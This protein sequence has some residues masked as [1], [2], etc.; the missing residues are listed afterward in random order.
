MAPFEPVVGAFVLAAAVGFGT[1]AHELLHAGCLRAAGVPCEIRRGGT[2]GG[3]LG[4]ALVG[5]L[6]SVHPTRIPE[7]LAAWQLRV[8]ALSPLALAVPLLAIGAGLVPDPFAGENLLAQLALIGW[9]AC[10]L[11]SPRDFGLFWHADA[12]L[13]G[14]ELPASVRES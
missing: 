3:G 5:A 13:A 1:V 8:A 14:D 7:G 2:E 4:G 11:P 10:A 9:L 6:A 12:V